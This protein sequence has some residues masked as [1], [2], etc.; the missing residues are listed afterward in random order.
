MASEKLQQFQK[1][2]QQELM[3][4]VN[5][6]KLGELFEKNGLGGNRFV[7]FQC[8]LNL[9]N[10]QYSDTVGDPELK[11]SL[12]AIVDQNLVTVNCDC[13]NYPPLCNCC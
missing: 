1:E 9:T 13:C 11:A 10:A 6:S 2:I 3:N 8:I 12:Q 7:K 4:A 5:N